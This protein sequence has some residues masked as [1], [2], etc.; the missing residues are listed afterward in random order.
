MAHY[1]DCARSMS[2]TINE[3]FAVLPGQRPGGRGVYVYTDRSVSFVPFGRPHVQEG[4]IQEFLLRTRVPDIGEL[5]LSVREGRPGSR[6]N[7]P[8]GISYET[9]SIPEA[10]PVTPALVVIDDRARDV[11]SQVLRKRVAAIKDFIDDKNRYSTPAEAQRAFE[12]DRAA[13]LQKLDRCRVAG[14]PDLHAAVN[15]EMLK[16]K[17]GH[18]GATVWEREIKA[19]PAF[20]VPVV[21]S[22]R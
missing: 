17:L 5:F 18:P 4:D 6:S 14:D 11:L 8:P 15:E 13:Y 7:V 12:R 22:V 2:V 21:S 20:A 16:L 10:Y 19:R 9:E 3:Q 1:M